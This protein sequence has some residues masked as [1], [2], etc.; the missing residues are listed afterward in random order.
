MANQTFAVHTLPT[1]K[2]K[3]ALL[4][5]KKI[6]VE[7]HL[8]N[9]SK[10]GNFVKRFVKKR[11][12]KKLNKRIKKAKKARRDGLLSDARI[13]WGIIL[14]LAGLL[15]GLIFASWLAWIGGLAS[16]GGLILLIWGLIDMAA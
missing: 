6:S 7:N 14:I 3:Q 15:I 1:S 16:I 10:K 13:Y 4:E 8:G 2:A 12:I 11:L 9:I 5:Q